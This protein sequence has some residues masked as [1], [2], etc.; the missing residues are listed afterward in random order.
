MQVKTSRSFGLAQGKLDASATNCKFPAL[1]RTI[2]SDAF[3]GA[4][5]RSFPLLKQGAPTCK[6]E[7]QR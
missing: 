6:K 1:K 7:S 3:P 5:K 2:K 4:L